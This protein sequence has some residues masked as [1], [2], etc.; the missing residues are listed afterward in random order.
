VPAVDFQGRSS[1]GSAVDAESAKSRREAVK[2]RSGRDG[3]ARGLSEFEED[4][5]VDDGGEFAI[6]D[7]VG[8]GELVVTDGGNGVFPSGEIEGAFGEGGEGDFVEG[9]FGAS[10]RGGV[11]GED[12]V[13][14]FEADGGDPV[15]VL[16][17]IAIIIGAVEADVNED[18]G[19]GF[20]EGIPGG[21][22]VGDFVPRVVTAGDGLPALEFEFTR[23]TAAEADEGV[24]AGDEVPRTGAATVGA[25]EG[26]GTEGADEGDLAI[27]G[28]IARERELRKGG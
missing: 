14:V 7:G 23:G 1:V 4:E 10:A 3:M 21:F 15:S 12:G 18:G 24:E 13:I 5:A 11:V 16:T 27:V 22:K 19:L 9:F 28:G 6:G 25:H 26:G 8:A 2:V 20:N 17:S